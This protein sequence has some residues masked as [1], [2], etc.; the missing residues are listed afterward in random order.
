[1]NARFLTILKTSS[2]IVSIASFRWGVDMWTALYTGTY[3]AW[4]RSR[5]HTPRPPGNSLRDMP[6][7]D[8]LRIQ[9]LL[10]QREL[11]YAEH[12]ILT[13]PFRRPADSFGLNNSV[14]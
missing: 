7:T 2:A 13:F 9:L 12:T 11:L 14:R 5:P 6:A 1:M 3:Y 4:L 8:D 10:R